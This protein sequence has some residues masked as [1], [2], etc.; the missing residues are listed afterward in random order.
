MGAGAPGVGNSSGHRSAYRLP[1]WWRVRTWTGRSVSTVGIRTGAVERLRYSCPH[2]Q[3]LRRSSLNSPDPGAACPNGINASPFCPVPRSN[4]GRKSSLRNVRPIHGRRLPCPSPSRS[5][6]PRI[7]TAEFF[8][9]PRTGVL[10]TP[11]EASTTLH[12]NR[13]RDRRRIGSCQDHVSHAASSLRQ[14]LNFF[15]SDYFLSRVEDRPQ[16]ACPRCRARP[17]Q[18]RRQAHRL[19]PLSFH[20]FSHW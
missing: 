19:P 16:P 14:R 18:R 11:E 20:F 1:C 4:G 10:H 17:G 3:F 6:S 5:R 8:G 2:E 9:L 15:A 7:T 12:G 13:R